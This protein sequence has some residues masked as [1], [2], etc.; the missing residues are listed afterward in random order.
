M[1]VERSA[2]QRGMSLIELLLAVVLGVLLLIGLGRLLAYGQPR[3]R[4]G[5]ETYSRRLQD[6]PLP[7]VSPCSESSLH[8][9][10]SRRP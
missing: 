3:I 5:M 7:Y 10:L 6:P 1:S 4:S 2:Y 9:S 8:I